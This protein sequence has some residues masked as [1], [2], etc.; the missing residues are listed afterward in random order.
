MAIQGSTRF[1]QI[2]TSLSVEDKAVLQRAVGVET[3][4]DEATLRHL[5]DADAIRARAE[6]LPE[7]LFQLLLDV[8]FESGLLFETTDAEFELQLE[9]IFQAGL[10][11]P[12]AGEIPSTWLA[13]MEVRVALADPDEIADADLALLLSF[14]EDDELNALART[15]NI[16]L[17][18]PL[19]SLARAELVAQGMLDTAHLEQLVASLT[20]AALTLTLW[21]IQHDGP[22]PRQTV[23]TWIEDEEA[24]EASLTSAATTVLLRLGL[25]QQMTTDDLELLM[26]AS[27]LRIQ[28]VPLLT[29]VF[30]QA[31]IDSWNALRD[32]SQPSFRDSF[33]RGAAGS[34]LVTA[35]YRL[36]H[37]V[38]NEPDAE[39]YVDR[40]LQ[41]FFLY[42]PKKKTAGELASYHLDVDTPDAF[43]RHILRVWAG[44][45]D[46]SFTRA[47]IAAFDGDS[48][49]IARW[50]TERP[51]DPNE[52]AFERQ[53]W[54][55]TLIQLRGLL[56]ISL[57]CLSA[58]SWYSLDDLTELMMAVY[59]RTM[60]QY[61]RYRLFA[62]D[63]PHD[64][65]PVG[66]EEVQPLH[67][68]AL[69]EV[70][71]GIFEL[72]LE[73]IG[74]AQRDQS[75][76]LFLINSEAFR[77]FRET[78]HG[79]EGLWEAAE[80][81][82]GE[83]ADLW[84]PLPGEVG[85]S[86]AGLPDVR[87]HQDGS[88]SL[89]VHAPIGDLIRLAEWGTAR[90]EG[91]TF[92]FEFTEASFADEEDQDDLEELLVWLVVR[93]RQELPDVFRAMVP[94]SNSDADQPY[95]QV[96]A[97][98]HGYIAQI[99]EALDA[100][101]EAPS[102]ALMEEL[103]SWGD[104]LE[105]FLL[106]RLQRFVD[107]NDVES[108]LLRH[109]A[110]LLGEVR[111][112]AALNNLLHVFRRC[113]DERQEGAIGMALARLGQPA[114][115]T[116]IRFLHEPSLDIDK[117]VAVAGVLTSIG[118]LHP[119]L[120]DRTFQELRR[121]IRDEEIGDDVAT[122]LAAYTA[123]LGHPSGES[124][125]RELRDQGRWFDEALPF[126]DALWTAAIS[127]SLWGHPVYSA[128]LAQ[129]F[130][131]AWESE[132]VLRAAG[133]DEVMRDS[134]VEQSAVLGRSGGWRRRN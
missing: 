97:T 72:L 112:E 16:E 52:E 87:W 127:P 29:S 96:L 28:L 27:D 118:V 100:W 46:D 17:P 124:L 64:A 101:V 85:I 86:R 30:D 63:F 18:V 4:D 109:T 102:L 50:L 126:D 37:C 73:P 111:S 57:G 48:H 7:P 38:S 84:L 119:D 125:I 6:E 115:N 31:A 117:R 19:D 103:R 78:D 81:I 21:L 10:I 74:A 93:S 56:L 22:V 68:Q 120:A 3:A 131:N 47:F 55:E 70:I 40:L 122:I 116:L 108:P 128:P 98:S 43:A 77:V 80:S 92:R 26:I 5:A 76:T 53:L 11:V 14:Y 23:D 95:A 82:L 39:S 69:A 2:W 83:D 1:S 58:G 9:T 99:Y 71:S 24:T 79:F 94:L 67:R 89:P 105:E 75:R 129:V 62:D 32:S 33:P 13:P 8:C 106:P 42:D 114:L 15:H 66:T 54:L 20:P 133:I 134:T 34:P 130:P 110:V 41:E 51:Y 61:G 59:R 90:W 121:V 35:R 113:T 107:E 91:T 25:L 36:M 12:H 132:E 60:W 123:D 65:L 88:L 49:A 104:A 44:S 45:L